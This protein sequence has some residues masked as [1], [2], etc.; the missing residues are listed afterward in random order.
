[1]K[2][3][4]VFADQ[5]AGPRMGLKST[6]NANSA[7]FMFRT[8]PSCKCSDVKRVLCNSGFRHLQH[9]ALR[10]ARVVEIGEIV[11]KTQRLVNL[12][13]MHSLKPEHESRINGIAAMI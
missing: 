1:M 10:C 3:R 13:R 7:T 8:L 5:A 2:V 12:E 4:F 11:I 6:P 9:A